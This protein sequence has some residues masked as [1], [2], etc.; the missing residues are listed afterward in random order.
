MLAKD[1]DEFVSKAI[2]GIQNGLN[3]EA[4]QA[5]TQEL[6][7]NALTKNPNMTAEQWDKLKQ[8][9]MLFCFATTLKETP[10]LWKE[11]AS[12]LWKELQSKTEQP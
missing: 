7:Q 12:H 8:D 9:F 6:L 1:F 11:F 10:E 2:N 3:S 4:G 5:L